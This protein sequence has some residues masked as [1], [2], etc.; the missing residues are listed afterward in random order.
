M[1]EDPWTNEQIQ[2]RPNQYLAWKEA[3][4]TKVERE[5]KE[6]QEESDY[7]AF[8]RIFEQRGGDPSESRAMYKRFRGD[9]ALEEA[10]KHDQATRKRMRSDRSR[11]V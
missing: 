2:A 9:Q 6:A 11:A 5:R 1:T 7:Q 10:K 3:Q 8:R 4:R